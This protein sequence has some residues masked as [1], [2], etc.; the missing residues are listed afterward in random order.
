MYDISSPVWN[1]NLH[2]GFWSK[3]TSSI[4]YVLLLYLIRIKKHNVT[5]MHYK[6]VQ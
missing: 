4:L 3:A 2:L 6:N 5:V 1:V